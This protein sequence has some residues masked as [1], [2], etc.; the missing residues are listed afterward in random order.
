VWRQAVVSGDDLDGL[1][2]ARLLLLEPLHDV[3]LLRQL[4]GPGLVFLGE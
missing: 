2:R 1:E 3:D 4:G